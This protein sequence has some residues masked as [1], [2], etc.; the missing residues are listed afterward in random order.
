M[1][2]VN[3]TEDDRISAARAFDFQAHL[4]LAKQEEHVQQGEIS[5]NLCVNQ[6]KKIFQNHRKLVFIACAVAFCENA[7]IATVSPFFPQYA[8]SRFGASDTIVGLIFALF[9]CTTMMASPLIGM[10]LFSFG[11]VRMVALGMLLLACGTLLFGIADSLWV[12]F[13]A[14][15][16]QGL[17]SAAQS[18]A[19]LALMVDFIEDKEL[20]TAVGLQESAV[21]L[22]FMVGPLFGGGLYSALGFKFA[23]VTLACF[24]AAMFMTLPWII[25]RKRYIRSISRIQQH[26]KKSFRSLM[27]RTCVLCLFVTTVALACMGFLEPTFST[28]LSFVLGLSELSIGAVFAIPSLVYTVVALFAGPLAERL[29]YRVTICIGLLQLGICY[30]LIGPAPWLAFLYINRTATWLLE[31]SGLFMLGVGFALAVIPILPLIKTS[32]DHQDARSQDMIAS[33]FSSACSA[34]EFVGPLL[35]GILVDYLPQTEEVTCKVMTNHCLYGMQWA[36]FLFGSLLILLCPIVM[37]LIPPPHLKVSS[38]SLSFGDPT[39]PLITAK[40]DF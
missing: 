9:P 40:D 11:R 20:S 13:A 32:F 24:P 1:E 10:F 23:F 14:R 12:F 5:V 22:G 4:L 3:S 30:F 8:R 15:F 17:G 31:I 27:T 28:H 29:G 19:T 34:G 2:S 26:G 6:T 21:G 38:S 7:M 36:S 18:V 39:V 25:D 16:I 37:K 33:L 35:G